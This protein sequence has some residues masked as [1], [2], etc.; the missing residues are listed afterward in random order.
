[1]GQN[2]S[3]WQKLFKGVPPGSI[4]GP[5]LFNIFINDL[6]YVV[7]KTQLYNYADDN[8]ISYFHCDL[9]ILTEILI[10]ESN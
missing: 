4:L 2:T 8:T 7:K 3:S 1:M 5:L 9:N 6:F 10:E